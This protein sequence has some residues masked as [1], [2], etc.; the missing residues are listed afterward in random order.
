MIPLNF[1]FS[2][3]SANITF[4]GGWQAETTADAGGGAGDWGS[5]GDTGNDTGAGGGG[6]GGDETCRM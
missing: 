5:G 2:R 3:Q 6:G 4:A 1:T